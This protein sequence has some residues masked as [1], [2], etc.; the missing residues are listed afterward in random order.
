MIKDLNNSWLDTKRP[1]LPQQMESLVP[2]LCDGL[3]VQVPFQSVLNDRTETLIRVNYFNRF[4]VYLYGH[5][6]APL[7]SKI[8]H[9]LF[10]FVNI[11]VKVRVITPIHEM[12]DGRTVTIL[13]TLQ[14]GK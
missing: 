4:T 11:Q 8:Y 9:H 3:G 14:K 6:S 2:L 1:E 5:M 7:S 10:S 12:I 13:R